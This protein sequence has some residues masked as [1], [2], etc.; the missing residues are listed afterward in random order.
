MG[1]ESGTWVMYGVSEDDPECIH[2]VE[3][4]IEYINE[5][6]FLPLF[7]NDIPGF[8]LEE[9]TVPEYWWSGDIE[10]E[11][12]EWRE[13]IART[14][15]VAYGKFFDKKAGFI[16]KE[17][18]PYFAN[19]R[20]DGYDFDALWDD[21]KA[22]MKQKKIMDLFAEENADAELYSFEM[23][24]RAGFGKDGEKNFDG[25]V[26]DLEMKTY[27]CVRDFRQRK[28]KKGETY[29]WAI[30]VYATP[31]HIFGYEHVT[32]A[33][34]EEPIVSGKRIVTHMMEVYPIATAEQIR[35]VIGVPAG[36]PVKK[37]RK[38][39]K[40]DY[41]ANLFKDLQLDIKNPTADQ[42][43]GLEFVLARLKDLQQE[44]IR[45]RYEQGLTYKAIG[46]QTGR[47]RGR[48]SQICKQGLRRLENDQRRSWMIEGYEGRIANLGELASKCSKEFLTAGKVE[49]A[50]LLVQTPE[51]L[52]GITANQAKQLI[53]AGIFNIA[54]LREILN[55]DFWTWTIPGIGE[56]GGKR[57]VYAM[58]SAGLIDEN[59]EAYKEISDRNYRQI[60]F[61]KMRDLADEE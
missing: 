17:W 23:K 44:V 34:K 32:A 27:L 56:Q 13:I 50:A 40:V 31:E 29:G 25:T 9:R 36:A 5:I 57:I 14:G 22:S 49:Q 42:I 43:Y 12:W 35:K 54:A 52:P 41:P 58:L 26:T 10:R 1:N 11:P 39:K 46:E 24:Q 19:Y 16:S 60:K 7:K 20:G 55:T 53:K 15:Q 6:G 37:E 21:E 33:Y 48:C 59:F 3:Q 51:E 18:L 45:L 4:A 28:N 2:T 47:S 38:I 30:A 8:S 61:L